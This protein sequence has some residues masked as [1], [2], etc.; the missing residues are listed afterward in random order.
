MS[1]PLSGNIGGLDNWRTSGDFLCKD[2][3]DGI[4]CGFLGLPWQ[5]IGIFRVLYL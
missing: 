5:E 3:G 4:K 2:L 1:V